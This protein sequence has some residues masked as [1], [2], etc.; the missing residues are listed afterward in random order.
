LIDGVGSRLSE[1]TDVQGRGKEKEVSE[2]DLREEYRVR[3]WLIADARR[4][5]TTGA[6]SAAD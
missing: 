3:G 4:T 5:L 2:P 6:D 1:L